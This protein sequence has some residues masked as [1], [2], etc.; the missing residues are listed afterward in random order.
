[1]ARVSK[2]TV[3]KVV[4]DAN[5]DAFRRYR[6]VG[7]HK[8]YVANAKKC[9][10]YYVGK[11]WDEAD[12]NKLEAAGRPALTINLTM[13][14]VNTVAGEQIAKR[15]DVTF[16]PTGGAATEQVAQDLNLVFEKILEENQYEWRESQMFQDGLI[17][18]R[19][20]LDLRLDF[21]EHAAGEARFTAKDN[22]DILIDPDAKEYDPD[23]WSGF[24]ETRLYSLQDIE[25][26]FGRAK[27]RE[28]EKIVGAGQYY[29]DDSVVWQTDTT[30]GGDQQAR[31]TA[32]NTSGSDAESRR[33]KY[34]RV[35][36]RQYYKMQMAW[37]FVD[38]KLGDAKMVPADWSDAKRS[39]FAAA[40]GLLATQKLAKRI[41]WT[42][43]ADGILLH[44]DWSPYRHFTIIPYFCY[45]R[46]GKPI[47]MVT[48]LL[49]PQDNLNKLE[50]QTLSVVNSTANSGWIIEEDSLV[51]L[52]PEELEER[53]AST[54]L[55]VTYRKNSTPPAKIDA[56]SIPSGLDR[57]KQ[58]AAQALNAI[59]GVDDVLNG[60]ASGEFSGVALDHQEGRGLR[61]LAIPLDNLRQ[62]R[63]IMARNL[64]HVI[65][66]HYREER[67][68]HATKRES[69]GGN[70]EEVVLNRRDAAGRIINDIALG[71]Y[72]IVI[73]TRPARDTFEERQ[74]TEVLEL[75]SVGVAIPDHWVV[76]YSSLENKRELEKLI[77]DATGYGEMS[78]EDQEAARVNAEIEMMR[79][80]AELKE[81]EAKI[82][83]LNAKALL[84]EA[85]ADDLRAG[86][87]SQDMLKQR[88]ELEAQYATKTKEL[89]LR[90]ELQAAQGQQ[91]DA[92][93]NQK[94]GIALL[95][96]G[97]EQ[98]KT[99]T[100]NQGATS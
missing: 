1:M 2:R 24:I 17:E 47:G 36:S 45:F 97:L 79:V 64:L 3:D 80:E 73:G 13:D 91:Q 20:Y 55:V 95:N 59:S 49:S 70:T 86:E 96:A 71:D 57:M 81:I 89:D 87:G 11:Q 39:E 40:N 100:A 5:F 90:R 26:E 9:N 66:D 28:I 93:R 4:A 38:P 82:R 54:G 74:F 16:L 58:G 46:R 27:R 14:K 30:Y 18:E 25:D 67:V 37:H 72:S 88:Q 92:D 94:S 44:D 84:N 43:S 75:R 63:Y 77:A 41:R 8:E 52:T 31:G 53:G 22:R 21:S 60:T 32:W 83:D 61:K 68:F 42:V 56:N 78:P 65:K 12:K 19:G 10:D 98:E 6:D 33:V 50:S 99:R 69:A 48:N 35:L 85:K 29:A 62:S 23:S 76:R 7:K 15:V 34:V 51:D